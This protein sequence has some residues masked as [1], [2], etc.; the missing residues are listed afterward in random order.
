MM[1]VVA[2]VSLTSVA[3]NAVPDVS[4]AMLALG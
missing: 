4:V 3:A 1:R 2:A